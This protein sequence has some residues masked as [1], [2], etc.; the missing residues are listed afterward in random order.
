MD[1]RRGE[2]HDVAKKGCA[3]RQRTWFLWV[4]RNTVGGENVKNRLPQAPALVH[5]SDSRHW[6]ASRW[7]IHG[8]VGWMP[9]LPA[10]GAGRAVTDSRS[11]V[12]A[13][14]VVITTFPGSHAL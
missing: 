4:G 14:R 3:S 2:L 7:S 9:R 12:K 6:R 13:D 8:Q 1:L 11:G 10:A 5:I